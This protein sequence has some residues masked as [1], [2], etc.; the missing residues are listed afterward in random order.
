[1][2]FKFQKGI[3]ISW[4]LVFSIVVLILLGGIVG[5][6][7]LQHKI[8]VEKQASEQSLHIAEAG[9]NY[10]KWLINQNTT[11]T[12]S[13]IQ[14]RNDW[15]TSS[16]TIS[17]CGSNDWCGPYL[18]D[19]K[20]VDGNAIGN[21]EL[22]VQPKYICG[23]ILGVRAKSIGYTKN[24]SH[25]KRTI[26]AKFAATTIAEYNHIIDD[27][28]WAGDDR[29]IYGKYHANGGIRMDG[30]GNS[31]VTSNQKEW[32]CT[33]S[34]GCDYLHCPTGCSRSGY[35]CKCPGIFGSGSGNDLWKFDV[36]PFDFDG[37]TADFEKIKRL[38]V[39]NGKYY[40]PST[41]TDINADG[42]HLIFKDDG[43]FDIKIITELKT[44]YSS[45]EGDWVWYPEVIESEYDYQTNVTMPTDCGLIFVE[46]N[47]WVE[48]TVK[49]RKTVAS[50]NLINDGIDTSAIIN[51]NIDYTT[52]D[53]TDSFA[54]LAEN[55]VLIPLCSP[56]GDSDTSSYCHRSGYTGDQMVM[57]G[58]Y[59]AQKGFIGRRYYPASA[60]RGKKTE[61]YSPWYKRTELIMHGSVVS[62]KRVG[63]KWSCSGTY[64]SGYN[65]RYNYFDQK[66][67]TNPPPLLPYVSPDLKIVSW[68]ELQ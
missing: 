66:L 52:L 6:V 31:L 33:S 40:P 43:T 54:L 32:L 4:V 42:Y 68:E 3:I 23:Q 48:G 18:Y 41:T 15:C 65:Q 26:Q 14:D 24:Y 19:Y 45:N 53:G 49:G 27:A 37:I 16:E 67:A 22:C 50:A 9:I 51:W 20:D 61:S 35:A 21:F 34:F 8:S 10:Y 29:Q 13:D 12:Q 58:V 11:T 2:N 7:I 39:S 64:C 57:R 38:A 47:I 25:V 60:K 17:K 62:K 59:V 46:D 56:G 44:I 63:T 5:F 55:D 28:V 30:S 36:P 1:M